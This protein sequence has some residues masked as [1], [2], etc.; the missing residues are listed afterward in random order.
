MAV[1]NEER[2]ALQLWFAEFEPAVDVELTDDAVFLWS[3]RPHRSSEIVRCGRT[4]DLH[5]DLNSGLS[6]LVER[7]S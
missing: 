1:S 3:S 5:Q 2:D 4:N 6:Q 7:M